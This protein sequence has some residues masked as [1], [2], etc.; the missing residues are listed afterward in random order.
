MGA[1]QPVKPVSMS[2]VLPGPAHR[3]AG[4]DAQEIRIALLWEEM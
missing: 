3:A 4:E 1:S 2:L